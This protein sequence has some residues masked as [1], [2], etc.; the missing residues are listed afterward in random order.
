MQLRELCGP[1]GTLDFQSI[2]EVC[3]RCPWVRKLN[4]T[5]LG[6]AIHLASTTAIMLQPI[7]LQ[8]LSK[9]E[10]SAP[11]GPTAF[12]AVRWM[13]GRE[14]VGSGMERL[15]WVG[16]DGDAVAAALRAYGEE[17]TAENRAA[18]EAWMRSMDRKNS[19]QNEP[20]VAGIIAGDEPAAVEIRRANQDGGLRPRAN[21]TLYARDPETGSEWMLRPCPTA[22]KAAAFAEI[23]E[24]WGLGHYVLGAAV[25]AVDD[26]PYL[27]ERLAPRDMVTLGDQGRCSVNSPRM[28]LDPVLQDGSLHRWAVLDY[29]LGNPDRPPSSVLVSERR[30]AYLIRNEGAFAET[31]QPALDPRCFA[32]AYMTV[33]GPSGWANLGVYEKRAAWPGMAG[34]AEATVTWFGNQSEEPVKLTCARRGLASEGPLGRLRHLRERAAVEGLDRALREVWCG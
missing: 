9:G 1:G 28:S 31:F 3:A 11:E 24:A 18:V 20:V 5:S 32:P 16:E 22:P 30:A 6:D 14:P 4:P 23:A 7:G 10:E 8:Q 29:V 34:S 12:D 2:D 26:Q 17:P 15:A 25:V 27:A 33:W 21:G 19:N 13:T